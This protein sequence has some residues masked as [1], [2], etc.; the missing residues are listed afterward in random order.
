MVWTA[1]LALAVSLGA[2]AQNVPVLMLSDIHLDPLHDPS[3]GAKLAAAPVEQWD[4]I[5]SAPDTKDQEGSFEAVQSACTARGIDTDY[6]LFQASLQ[7]EKDQAKGI[8][9]VTVTGDLLVHSFECRYDYAMGKKH[10]P[11]YAEFAEKTAVYVMQHLEAAFPGVPVYLAGGN[12]DSSCGDY[13]F[14][15][16]DRYLKA[17]SK[18]VVEGLRG[19]IPSE[20]KEVEADYEAGGYFAVTLKEP[21]RL[22]LLVLDDIYL[23]EKYETCAGKEE[24]AGA[25]AELAWLNRELSAARAHGENVWVLGHVPPGVNA[26]S[27]LSKMKNLC[28]GAKVTMFLGSDK[29]VDAMEKHSDVIRLGL[30]GHTHSDELRLLGGKVP[31]KLVGSISPVNGNRPSFTIAEVSAKTATLEDYTVYVASNMTGLETTWSKEYDYRDVYKEPDFSAP[32]VKDLV[33]KFHADAAGATPASHA[34]ENYFT[35]G[36]L[37][38]LSFVWPK[39]VCG[40]DNLTEPSFRGCVC[41]ATK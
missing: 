41:P 11:G 28:E 8:A 31:I 29:L 32:A 34:Y 19:V 39:Y 1:S 36:M 12:N 14:D 27:T 40:M 16:R 2:A 17:T 6:A 35:P 37:P 10:A 18:V 23:S 15:E 13:R 25:D 5:L 4:A 26:Y 3:K 33:A 22:R 24:T 7:A 30:F 38:L 20:A 9:F 21:H